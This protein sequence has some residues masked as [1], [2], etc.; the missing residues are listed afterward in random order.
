MTQATMQELQGTLNTLKWTCAVIKILA[1]AFIGGSLG[2]FAT[3]I[4]KGIKKRL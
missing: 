3:E 1:V 2:Y 4:Y